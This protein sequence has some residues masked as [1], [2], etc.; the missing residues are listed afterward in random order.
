[1]SLVLDFN[2]FVKHVGYVVLSRVGFADVVL[3]ES[4]YVFDRSQFPSGDVLSRSSS[5]LT[6]PVGVTEDPPR[7]SRPPWRFYL[8]DC[9]VQIP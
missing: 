9:D 8:D 6:I 7:S 2:L 1:M 3:G 4:R 5:T